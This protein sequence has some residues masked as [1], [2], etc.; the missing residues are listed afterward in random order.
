MKDVIDLGSEHWM[1]W[2]V[3]FG[4]P[5]KLAGVIVWHHAKPEDTR[6]EEMHDGC[7]GGAVP[8]DIPENTEDRPKWAVE[9]LDPLTLSPSLLCHCGDH[10]WIQGGR[11]VPA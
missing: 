3:L 5:Q 6:C 4:D 1:Q 9:S 7:C 2:Y 11:W 8:F 10:G